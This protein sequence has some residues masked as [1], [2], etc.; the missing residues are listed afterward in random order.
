MGVLELWR[1]G[2]SNAGLP[3]RQRDC[4]FADSLSPSLSLLKRLLEVEGGVAECQSRRR[5]G[6]PA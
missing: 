4:H 5:L 3:S 6:L 2:M 1:T